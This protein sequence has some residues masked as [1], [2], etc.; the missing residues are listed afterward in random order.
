[1]SVL[2]ALYTVLSPVGQKN[3]VL[4]EEMAETSRHGAGTVEAGNIWNS[5]CAI[6]IMHRYD[7][8]T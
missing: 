3:N 4:Q 7:V 6:Q 8:F 1:M 2:S 5:T